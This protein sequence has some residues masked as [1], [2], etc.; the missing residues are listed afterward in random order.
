VGGVG[1]HWRPDRVARVLEYASW[2]RRIAALAIDWLVSTLVTIG[3]MG[4]GDYTKPGGPGPWIVLGVFALE[5][6]VLTTL[7][8]GSFGQ[9]LVRIRVLTTEGRPLSLLLAVART[10]SICLV[11]PPLIYKSESGRGLHD[12]WT[13]S[14]AYAR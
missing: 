8:G 7:T 9:L 3:F 11:V 10:I 1:A 6:A 13:G 2:P 12:L 5:V 14:A 4:L